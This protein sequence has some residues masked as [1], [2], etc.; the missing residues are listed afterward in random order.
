MGS[1]SEIAA[2]DAIARRLGLQASGTSTSDDLRRLEASV[3]ESLPEPFSLFLQRFNGCANA[4]LLHDGQTVVFDAV[5]D[6]LDEIRVGELEGLGVVPFAHDLFGN[7]WALALRRAEH[8]AAPGSVAFI[9]LSER[10]SDDNTPLE[11]SAPSFL[12]FL[13]G[14]SLRSGDG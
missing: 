6:I 12:R 9:A 2:I 11:E 1:Q 13:E 5:S 14:L 10:H 8:G 7:C 3:G 4:D